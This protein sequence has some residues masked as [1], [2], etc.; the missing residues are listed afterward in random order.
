[1]IKNLNFIEMFLLN[2]NKISKNK[3]LLMNGNKVWK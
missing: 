2:L 3:L 1:M